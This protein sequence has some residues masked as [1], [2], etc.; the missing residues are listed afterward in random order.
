MTLS[1]IAFLSDLPIWFMHSLT[2]LRCILAFL[3]PI[4]VGVNH[5]PIKAVATT[6]YS[7][8]I[9]GGR[10]LKFAVKFPN[11]PIL[12]LDSGLAVLICKKSKMGSKSDDGV[13]VFIDWV[14]FLPKFSS[15]LGNSK[16]GYGLAVHPDPEY[17]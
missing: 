14:E 10:A 15:Q 3:Q 16:P 6:T 2:Y 12:S 17:I 8:G 4:T 9:G 1:S 5:E 7:G 13:V 11:F